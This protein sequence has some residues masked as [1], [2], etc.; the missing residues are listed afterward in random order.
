MGV[1]DRDYE[2]F[3]L[4]ILKDYYYILKLT[5]DASASEIK[6]AYRRLALECHPDHHQ[7]DPEAEEKFKQLSEAY[8][9]LGDTQK[10]SDY[11]LLHHPNSTT[12]DIHEHFDNNMGSRYQHARRENECGRKPDYLAQKTIL[13]IVKPGQL[14]EFLLT[15]EEAQFGTERLVLIIMGKRQQRY[16]IRIPGG[17]TQGTQFKAI[18][19]RNES[20]YILVRIT[21]LRSAYQ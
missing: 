11:D 16:R 14:Y 18:L 17:M 21:I 15:P 2:R 13:N 19:G 9:V 5:R 4:M 3:Y 8:S 6:D 12:S 10:R 7:E 1:Y 20:R